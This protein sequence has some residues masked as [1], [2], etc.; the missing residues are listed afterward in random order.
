MYKIYRRVCDN[1][2]IELHN[3]YYNIIKI[4]SYAYSKLYLSKY[5][6]GKN[7]VKTNLKF[8]AILKTAKSEIVPKNYVS[9]YVVA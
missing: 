3:F 2:D 9:K 7:A 1:K 4:I 5:R 6:K 8:L